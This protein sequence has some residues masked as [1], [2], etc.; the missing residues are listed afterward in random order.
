[1][2]ETINNMKN[3]SSNKNT[4]IIGI[5]IVIILAGGWYFYSKGS[6][7]SSTSQLI[8]SSPDSATAAVGA[9]VL[10]ILN[11]VSS[12]NIDT[13]FFQTPAYQSLVDYSIAVPPQPVGR[14][15]PFA[16]V[17]Q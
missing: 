16:P 4:I 7:G 9:S 5:V 6:S 8:S 17:G 11:S 3:P 14:A 13:S 1:M 10:N 15:N 2:V 12:I